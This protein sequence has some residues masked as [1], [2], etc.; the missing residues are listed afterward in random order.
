MPLVNIGT[1]N[2]NSVKSR[3][4]ILER[5]L[6][7][8]SAPKLLALQETKT[9]NE[10]F[11][12]AAF[13]ALGY[14]CCFSGMRQYNGVAILSKLGEP[15]EAAFGFDDGET[16]EGMEIEEKSR[17]LRARF[18]SLSVINTYVPQ[19]QELGSQACAY[20]LLFLARLRALIERSYSPDGL[21]LW[22][23]DM[24][25]AP[26]S[27]DVSPEYGDGEDTMRSSEIRGAYARVMDWG[28]TD[29]FRRLHGESRCYSF[30]DYRVPNALK[31]DIGWH[32]D[33]MN[34]TAPLAERC[35][36][37]HIS[38]SLRAMEKPSDHTAVVAEFELP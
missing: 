32:I 5:W 11:P 34:A 36:S 9:R 17:V 15:D 31:R 3:L 8:D 30:W 29:L 22:T 26:D 12:A 24:N 4:P 35:R 19:G 37:I 21:V 23:G 7:L 25:V 28:F 16:P 14:T 6:A 27:I 1:F 18:G 20:K 33:R 2:V 13:E 10:D 38:R